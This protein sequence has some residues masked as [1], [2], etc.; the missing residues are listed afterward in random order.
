MCALGG[1]GWVRALCALMPHKH[2]RPREERRSRWGALIR[3]PDWARELINY[4]QENAEGVPARLRASAETLR[5][6]AAF[7][8]R[9]ATNIENDE[10][11]AEEP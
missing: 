7:L 3:L 6:A 1:R 2:K 11:G 4:L 8:E 5:T 9:E 10:H